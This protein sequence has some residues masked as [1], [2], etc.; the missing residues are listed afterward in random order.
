M[1][2]GQLFPSKGSFLDNTVSRRALLTGLTWC[3][4]QSCSSVKG[5]CQIPCCQTYRRQ[6]IDVN[7]NK[8]KLA[9]IQFWLILSTSTGHYHRYKGRGIFYGKVMSIGLLW[10]SGKNLSG[11][12][13]S[14]LWNYA[15]LYQT[16]FSSTLSLNVPHE[17]RREET[18]WLASKLK[19][20][21][22]GL[23]ELLN[24]MNALLHGVDLM[25]GNSSKEIIGLIDTYG[26]VSCDVDDTP[27][28]GQAPE[29]FNHGMMDL[30]NIYCAG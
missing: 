25:V 24:Q 3:S 10:G 13:S 11:T 19:L 7:V 6:H 8:W 23:H 15:S 28:T 14:Q 4:N 21:E 26:K 1:L 12:Q 27:L 18:Q 30:T 20:A 9:F 22:K 16:S 17:V 29:I 5:G 2:L